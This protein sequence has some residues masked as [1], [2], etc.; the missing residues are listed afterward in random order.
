MMSLIQ[1]YRRD[2]A[3]KVNEGSW[4]DKSKTNTISRTNIIGKC[5]GLGQTRKEKLRW[6]FLLHVALAMPDQGSA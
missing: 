2:Q 5:R 4:S 6:L 1:D 3:V